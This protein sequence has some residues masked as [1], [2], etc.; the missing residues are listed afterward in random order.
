MPFR[1]VASRW[2]R[3]ICIK[4]SEL[5]VVAPN[6]APHCGWKTDHHGEQASGIRPPLWSS[7]HQI[8]PV[9]PAQPC[10]SGLAVVW[11]EHWSFA[12]DLDQMGLRRMSTV[13]VCVLYG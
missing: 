12:D 11:R 1:M 3:L 7:L 10:L 5:T 8:Y 2:Q 13:V 9:R 6:V 4:N